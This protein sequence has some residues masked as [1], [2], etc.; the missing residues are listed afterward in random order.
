MYLKTSFH[1]FCIVFVL[2]IYNP[3]FSQNIAPILTARGNQY[4]C[5]N[6]QINIVTDFDIV[7][8]DDIGIEALFVQISTGYVSNEDTLLLLNSP[9]NIITSWNALEGKLTLSG[10]ASAPVSYVDL[11]AAIK[12][13]VFQSTS[14]NPSHKSFSITIGDANYL[15]STGHYY[16][17]ISNYGITW[18]EAK[19][20]AENKFYYG[21]QGYLAT[22]TSAE[23]AQLTGEQAAG[24]GWIG[25]TDEETEGIWKWVT[26]PEAG[27]VFWNGGNNGSTP[28]YANW[29]IR[30]PDNAH[31]GSGEDYLHVTDPTIGNRGAWNDLRIGGDGPG[32]YHPKGYIVEYG[33]T[34]GD[35]VLNIAASTS[36][37]TTYIEYTQSASRCDKG[38]V[39]LEA[40]ATQGG[41]VLWFDAPTGGIQL[42]KGDSYTVNV[43]ATTTYYVI[44]SI[45]ECLAGSSKTAVTATVTQTPVINNVNNSF[46]CGTGSGI[47]SAIGSAGIVNWYDAPIGGT[48]LYTGTSYTVSVLA[49]TTYYVEASLNGCASARTPVTMEVFPVPEFEVLNFPVVYCLGSSPITL[50]TFNTKGNYTYQWKNDTGQVISDLPYVEVNSG[51]LYTV[52]ATSSKGCDADLSIL[53]KESD[54]ATIT[55]EDITVIEN[56]E[57]NSISINANL[58]IGDYEFSLDNKNG[59]YQ[60]EPYFDS[61]KAGSHIIYVNDKNGCG[62][63]TSLEIF[64]L[65]FPKFFTPNND[66][67]NDTWK[68]IGLGTQYTNASKVSVY[69]RYGKL[70]KQLNAKSASWDG[71]FRGTLLPNSDY[72]FVA[73]LIEFSGNIRTY[74]GHFSLV[75]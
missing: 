26:G 71:T 69:N 34:P 67:Q 14:N 32:P 35:P 62:E 36:I 28:N 24:A 6:S 16:E 44:A 20:E 11:I 68:I 23:E 65:G 1:L 29:N 17:F 25:G 73:E 61:V 33:G 27:T 55:Y 41:D 40:K 3:V 72:W 19:T 57:N 46:I 30:Q 4:Y 8:P 9:A 47:L 63:P 31:G 7:D 56:S 42:Y 54:L 49:T 64:I 53:V 43:N 13:V 70:V 50:A 74:R 51:G 12:N 75:R 37:Y 66:G 58:G 10:V 38:L 2:F 59:F 18:T 60:D 5:P 15:P 22:I 21:L 52:V 39:T 48:L 45:N